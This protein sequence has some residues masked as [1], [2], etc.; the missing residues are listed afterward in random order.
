MTTE[1]RPA[2][3]QTKQIGQALEGP[4]PN[5]A[6]S[7]LID[8]FVL[9]KGITDDE[10]EVTIDL[11]RI[12]TRTLNN[13]SQ[14]TETLVG[15]TLTYRRDR[16]TGTRSLC[17]G[18]PREYVVITVPPDSDGTILLVSHDGEDMT[19]KAHTIENRIA[20]EN[21]AKALLAKFL[22]KPNTT[23]PASEV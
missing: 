22:P 13:G 5:N 17:V 4:L 10:A 6:A 21:K 23:T 14:S 15:P 11:R 18:E 7:D 20:A 3:Q 16:K 8:Q 1:A 19:G 12:E 2:T 9:A